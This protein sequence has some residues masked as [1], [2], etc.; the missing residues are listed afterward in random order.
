MVSS[1]AFGWSVSRRL[2]KRIASVICV[3]LEV[4]CWV[5]K[6]EICAGLQKSSGPG[7]LDFDKPYF[8][9]Y[10]IAS[11][12]GVFLPIWW[13]VARS[14]LCRCMRR[15]RSRATVTIV[16]GDVEDLNASAFRSERL[17]STDD[18]FAASPANDNISNGVASD[19]SS[20]ARVT[21]VGVHTASTPSSRPEEREPNAIETLLY[22]RLEYTT[23]PRPPT[24]TRV[25]TR[26]GRCLPCGMCRVSGPASHERTIMCSA[27]VLSVAYLICG[28]LYVISLNQT[29]VSVNTVVYNAQCVVVFFLSV[30][31]LGE[32]VS[33]VKALSVLLCVA[34][35]VMVALSA[36]NSGTDDSPTFSLFGLIAVLL[37]MIIYAIYEVVFKMLTSGD[38]TEAAILWDEQNP[39][40][41]SSHSSVHAPGGIQGDTISVIKRVGDVS[42]D[43]MAVV[44]SEPTSLV[45]PPRP[46]PVQSAF[47][48][49]G[50]LGMASMVLFWPGIFIA[51]WTGIETW[52]N[53]SADVWYILWVS[54]GL[55]AILN[56]C[57]LLGI[58]WSSPL[59]MSVGTLLTIPASVLAD[60]F[61][62]GYELEPM[63]YVGM[64]TIVLGF[65]GL[66]ALKDAK[67]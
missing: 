37:S 50:C 67:E 36:S 2:W 34:G 59:F 53:P 40:A 35:V 32:S 1:A 43:N 66:T 54:L 57:V 3:I 11:G 10:F 41:P 33:W 64:A 13:L 44:A 18:V 46:S 58:A 8:I 49:L 17:D 15:H 28:L 47:L 31:L 5:I 56:V 19:A 16:P 27:V 14:P 23:P 24:M 48:F 45:L 52:K 29:P 30:W 21:K 61:V 60:R 62:H 22:R 63:S 20:P 12:Y 42:Y 25:V 51:N 55:D 9:S 4:A 65:V 26:W 39:P 6:A 7:A 38:S